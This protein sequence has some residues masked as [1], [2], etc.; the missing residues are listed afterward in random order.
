M[1]FK[2]KNKESIITKEIESKTISKMEEVLLTLR[3]KGRYFSKPYSYSEI[4]EVLSREQFV[5]IYFMFN[6]KKMLMEHFCTNTT[7]VKVD[8]YVIGKHFFSNAEELLTSKLFP[9]GS[10][11]DNWD[12]V[13][14]IIM[15]DENDEQVL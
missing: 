4:K 14:I 15:L 12:K 2:K 5:S 7:M 8:R 1:F 6:N 10:I 9:E 3:K 13:K 11:K